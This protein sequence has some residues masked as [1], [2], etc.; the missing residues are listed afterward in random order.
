MPASVSN[1]CLDPIGIGGYLARIQ[2]KQYTVNGVPSWCAQY[3][4]YNFT[5]TDNK[6]PIFE[7]EL[8][9][10]QSGIAAP[11]LT[12]VEDSFWNEFMGAAIAYWVIDEAWIIMVWYS[13][14]IGTPTEPMRRDK[15]IRRLAIFK[16]FLGNLYPVALLVMGIY[17]VYDR[18]N[19]N[20][21]CGESEILYYPDSHAWY[22]FFCA[23]LV[24]YALELLVWPAIVVNKV[25]RIFRIH[26]FRRSR[27][28]GRGGKAE[29]FE[30]K[31]GCLLKCLQ[32]ATRGK[33]EERTSKTVGS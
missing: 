12:Y 5:Y 9:R 1:R 27:V 23:L 10:Q 30:R 17:H 29:R 13:A 16:T 3:D 22:G 11:S 24:S 20:Y 2:G 15:Y 4:L 31:L 8:T 28:E 6:V 21:G 18:R 19:N 33:M 26:I 25:V 7:E 14:S 32:C